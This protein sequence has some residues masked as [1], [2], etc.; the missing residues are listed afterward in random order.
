MTA[1]PWGRRRWI[2]ESMSLRFVRVSPAALALAFLPACEGS[3][4]PQPVGPI[5]ESQLSSLAHIGSAGSLP[6]PL[7]DDMIAPEGPAEGLVPG[8][9]GATGKALAGDAPR[10]FW[11]WYADGNTPPVSGLCKPKPPR[12]V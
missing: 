4:T 12:F 10:V 2:E 7:A 1:A 11:T 5:D 6:I 9:S 8:L 3:W